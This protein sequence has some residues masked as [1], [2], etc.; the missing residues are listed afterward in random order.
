MSLQ[1]LS[2]VLSAAPLGAFMSTDLPNLGTW[3]PGAE[4]ACFDAGALAAAVTRVR[5]PLHVVREGPAGRLGV[6]FGGQTAPNGAGY[7]LLGTLPALYPEWLGDRSFCETHGVRF[8][9]VVGEMARAI[10]TARMVIAMARAGMMGFFGAGGLAPA[11]VARRSTRSR[12]R[13]A[14][15]GRPGAPTSSIRRTAPSWKT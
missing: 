1:S 7:L 15:T 14:R 9:Y 2:E 10:T 12:P 4:P 13:L 11:Q 6:G 8:P 5:E 3:N